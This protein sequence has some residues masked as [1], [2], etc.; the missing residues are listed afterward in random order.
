[1]SRDDAGEAD[2]RRGRRDRRPPAGLPHRED[3]SRRGSGGGR[4][5]GGGGSRMPF[6]SR[7]PPECD[8]LV[9]QAA[10]LRLAPGAS[11]AP[12]AGNIGPVTSETMRSAGMP[13]DFEAKTAQPRRARRG[14]GEAPASRG[15]NHKD[16][17][18]RSRPPTAAHD[19]ET[20]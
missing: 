15:L 10:A 13:V 11:G 8:R 7:V 2:A 20:P 6:S 4:L 9:D 19:A 3:R 17:E 1:M 5:P 18:A 12:L 14:A 16:T